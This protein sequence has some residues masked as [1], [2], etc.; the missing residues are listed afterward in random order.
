MMLVLFLKEEKVLLQP[1]KPNPFYNRK[2]LMMSCLF[3]LL[4]LKI[5]HPHK[6]TIKRKKKTE[7]KQKG[8]SERE[9]LNFL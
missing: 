8:E 9:I 1:P 6:S 2:S 5:N 3:R 7:D 4:P